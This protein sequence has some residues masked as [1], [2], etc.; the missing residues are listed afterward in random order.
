MASAFNPQSVIA[1]V[2]VE[3][4]DFG[5]LAK[6]AV[7]VQNR[8]LE[9]FNKYKSTITSLLNTPISSDDNVKFRAD[10]F[11]KI[12]G[13][14]NNLQGV[15]FSNPGN[16]SVASNLMQPLIKDPEFLADMNFNLMQNAEM[17]K[18]EQIK[19]STDPKVNSQYSPT[20]EKAMRY[21]YMDMKNAKRGDGSIMKVGVQK[22]MPFAN[23]QKV[24]DEAAIALK[25]TIKPDPIITGQWIIKDTFGNNAIPALTQWAR[26]QLGDA[27]DEQILVTNKVQFRDQLENVMAGNPNLT[28]E[29]AYQQI[30]KDNSLGIYQN[31]ENYKTSLTGGMTN[32]DKQIAD[33]KSR[34][35]NK[36]PKGSQEEQYI[37][38]LKALKEEY[39]RELADAAANSTDKDQDLQTAFNQF[40][41]NPEYA[42]MPLY[43]DNLAKQWAASYANTHAERDIEVNQYGLEATK[44]AYDKQLKRMDQAHDLI[45]KQLDFEN[46]YRLKQMELGTAGGQLVESE[47]YSTSEDVFANHVKRAESYLDTVE[48]SYFDNDVLQVAT[49]TPDLS[50][51]IGLPYDQI[52][53][54]LTT[55]VKLY[56]V[57]NAQGEPVYKKNVEYKRA[58]GTVY[59]LAFRLNPRITKEEL[60]KLRPRQLI[61]FIEAGVKNYSGDKDPNS[62][63]GKRFKQAK[64]MITGAQTAMEEYISERSNLE[65]AVFGNYTGA[66]FAR[67]FDQEAWEGYGVL[68]PA[69]G[70]SPAEL[71]ELYQTTMPNYRKPTNVSVTG[72]T[73]AGSTTEDKFNYS[74][75]G[76]AINAA[77]YVTDGVDDISRAGFTKGDAGRKDALRRALG[78]GST[79]IKD[80]L[81]HEAKFY[82]ITVGGREYMQVQ[83]PVKTGKKGDNKL[84][85]LDI[86]VSSGSIAL[87]IPR[88]KA[89]GLWQQSQRFTDPFGTVRANYTYGSLAEVPRKLFA[90]QNPV[91]WIYEGLMERGK[92]DLKKSYLTRY[93]IDGGHVAFDGTS[94]NSKMWV[95]IKDEGR[96]TNIEVRING[97]S[98]TRGDY[99][100]DNAYWSNVID[101]GI[102]ES[103]ENYNNNK[104]KKVTSD[105]ALHR[106]AYLQNPANYVSV[107]DIPMA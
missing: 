34:M 41:Q 32:I 103:L 33:I 9:G 78:G 70:L 90:N 74:A 46:S 44:F 61:A 29:E 28:K 81:V 79:N 43:K 1:D 82:P 42:M 35:H 53:K 31:Y 51:K 16:V 11:K 49:S 6:A 40:M 12:D 86:E 77:E 55:F 72:V 102:R 85:D 38:Q 58:L 69:A 101:K 68:K 22:Y 26:Q 13:Y 47:P 88:E 76:D 59:A 98:L 63:S 105:A 83:L 93:E 15:D 36:I 57:T 17:R 99:N 4:P 10:Y 84:A 5:M 80:Y 54:D 56:G 21:N 65:K 3:A 95:V 87:Y 91:G 66:Q 64:D 60:A 7:S 30:A 48:Q 62:D 2:S 45:M 73:N 67:L 52:K 24:L 106:S 25:L 39:K 18:L 107:E 14:L 19:M 37:A 23:L 75:W 8:Y 20:L 92:A 27:Y 50:D 94:P 96:F 89:E 71:E 97:Q 104:T 100:S